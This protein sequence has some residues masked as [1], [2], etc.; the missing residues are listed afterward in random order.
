VA[1]QPNKP[2]KRRVKN[3]E[4]FRERADKASAESEKPKRSLK[5]TGGKITKPVTGP[6]GRAASKVWNLKPVKLL[7]KPLRLIGRILFP[8]YF[9][10]SW[11]ELKQV[12]WPSWNESRRLTVAVLLFAVLFGAIIAGVDYGLDKVFRN[13]L[14]K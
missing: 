7:H 10:E 3:P 12:T 8:R 1:D 6:S 4:T 9:R 2:D 14:L 13:I 5:A 11:R